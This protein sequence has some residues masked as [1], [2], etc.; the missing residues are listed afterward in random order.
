MKTTTVVK[1]WAA[2]EEFDRG[3]RKQTVT[4]GDDLRLGCGITIADEM[5][6]SSPRDQ[7][8]VAGLR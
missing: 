2:A 7:E 6:R 3:T 5:G 4:Q 8:N 1:R